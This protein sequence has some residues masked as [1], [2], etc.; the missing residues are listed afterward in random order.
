MTRS[1]LDDDLW[2][3]FKALYL[4]LECPSYAECYRKLKVI[5]AGRYVPA[6]QTLVR[7][8]EAEIAAAGF[9]K[10]RHAPSGATLRATSPAAASGLAREES[11]S[12]ADLKAT[13]QALSADYLAP[14]Q[15]EAEARQHAPQY[16]N[17]GVA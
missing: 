4:R 11:D 2:L 6:L 7:R 9:R 8:L 12:T 1:T 14:L 17:G 10:W 3:A 16:F 5:A 13:L 15:R